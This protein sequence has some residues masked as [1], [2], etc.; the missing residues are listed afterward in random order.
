VSVSHNI[1]EFLTSSKEERL[2]IKNS[3]SSLEIGVLKE[4]S[5]QEN[6]VSL[7][8]DSVSFLCQKGHKVLVESN[9]GL[10]SSFLDND[11]IKAGAI[12]SSKE[13]V[14]KSDYILK[15]EPLTL[16]EIKLMKPNQI[17]FSAVQL[18]TRNFEFFDLL[19]KKNITSLAFEFIKDKMGEFPFVRSM[20]EIAGKTSI[21][22]AGEYLSNEHGGRGLMF[23]GVSGS[24]S[25]NVLII[26]AGNV[27][28]YACQAALG[29]G[30]SITV[31]DD[32]LYKLKRI[33]TNVSKSIMTS[34]LQQSQLI[35]SLIN[36]DVLIT[37]KRLEDDSSYIIS[38]DMVKRMKNGS[39]I[40]DVSIDQGGCCETSTIT[41][42]ESPIF[43]KH[44]VIHYCV[45]NIASRVSRSASIS[46][47]NILC[48][49]INEISFEGGLENSIIKYEYLRSG[50][51]TFNSM[52][53]NQI[54]SN[55]FSYNFKDLNLILPFR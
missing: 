54:I 49:I 19:L 4:T 21:L 23:G 38:E 35:N 2:E 27:A 48:S 33:Q 37:A 36:T 40:I 34:T 3:F 31:F 15:I 7:T 5:F 45:P 32:S 17:V 44:G 14:I 20:S 1:K 46:I 50:V 51:Y 43:T 25:T 26:G 11:Y 42:H 16:S 52:L 28:E 6:R 29:L 13:D 39:V 47:S 18:N 8:P 53:T 30:A 9:A 55:K 10:K 22:I 24:I 41:N 12:I